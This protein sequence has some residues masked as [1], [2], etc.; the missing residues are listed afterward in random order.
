M[1]PEEILTAA[2]ERA[3]GNGYD[4]DFYH[5]DRIKAGLSVDATREHVSD[6]LFDHSFAKAFWGEAA[7]KEQCEI[8]DKNYDVG[9]FVIGVTPL[10]KVCLKQL[11]LSEDRLKYIEQYL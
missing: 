5:V 11:A 10:W 3:V 8:I 6:I 9:G 4:C 1:K 2:I 7:T